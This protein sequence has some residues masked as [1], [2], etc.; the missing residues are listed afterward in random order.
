MRLVA[1]FAL[2][3]H[4]KQLSARTAQVLLQHIEDVPPGRRGAD[5][6]ALLERSAMAFGEYFPNP[7]MFG[8]GPEAESLV[9]PWHAFAVEAFGT[10]IL[11]M[12]I[13]A[14]VDRRNAALPSKGMAPFFIGFTVAILISL[15]API[16][17]AG[18]NPAL[19]FPGVEQLKQRHQ[20]KYNKPAEATTGPAYAAVQVVADALG[21]AARADRDGLRDAI[22]A[23]DMKESVIGPIKFN[24]DGTGQVVTIANQW[25]NGQ[26]ALV[27]PKEH[28]VGQLLPAKAWNER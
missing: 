15:F 17:Q 28:A 6:D 18:W 8:T 20:A 10:A 7:A 23:T 16:T 3:F 27:W 2:G 11:A 22:A 9:S 14:V 21:R 25:Q 19:K 26:Q 1:A 4:S 13:F 5:W 24:P 12:V